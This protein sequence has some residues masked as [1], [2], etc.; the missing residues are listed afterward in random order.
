MKEIPINQVLEGDS[1]SILKTLPSESINCVMTSPPYWALRDYGVEGQLGLEPTFKGYIDKLCDIFDEVKRV[2]RKDGTCWVNLGD[3]YYGGNK[4]NDHVTSKTQLNNKGSLTVQ[5]GVFKEARELPNKSL[6]L[7]PFRFAIEMINRGWILRNDI[8]WYKRNSMPSSTKDRFAN[9]WEHLFFFVKSKKYYFDLDS[10]R[11]PYKIESAN[12]IRAGFSDSVS[13]NYRVREAVKGTLTAKFGEMYKSTPEEIESY[14][15]PRAREF[16]K[17]R[18]ANNSKPEKWLN[19][20]GGNPG[21]HWDITTRGH[22]FAHF[23][24]YPPE[25]CE[26]PIKCGCPEFV[27]N[28]CEKPREKIVEPSENYK[29]FLGKGN[30]NEHH[31]GQDT[32]E[33][34]KVKVNA[35]Y[36]EKGYTSCSCD[37]GFSGG[38][39]LDPFFGSGTTG[40]VAL[41]QNKNFVGIEL[42]PEYIKIANER[43]KPLLEQQKII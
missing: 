35:E 25:L 19:E 4:D 32:K 18:K 42:N 6:C 36:I 16:R 37:A 39:V 5:G 22:P 7:I 29:K 40:L 33:K 2:L 15:S 24:V 28:E 21:D 13:F 38:I 1:L 12:P 20:K 43:L 14:G 9:K 3:T 31:A 27:C 8:V 34:F 11:K 41:K 30:L 17:G 10:V 23:A 26:T